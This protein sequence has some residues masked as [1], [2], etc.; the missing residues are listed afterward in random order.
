VAKVDDAI[1][2]FDR[3]N[4]ER[5]H[6]PWTQTREMRHTAMVRTSHTMFPIGTIVD[7]ESRTWPGVNKPGGVARII[8]LYVDG[9]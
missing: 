4:I 5:N 8:A 6:V 2:V 3:L 1:Y 7:I 9:N